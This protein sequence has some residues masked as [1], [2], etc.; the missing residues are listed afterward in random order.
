MKRF[1][2]WL[3]RRFGTPSPD[4]LAALHEAD[5]RARRARQIRIE[6][7]EGMGDIRRIARENGF[8]QA[9]RATLIGRSV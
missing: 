5:E 8:E 1:Q 7:D 4:A 2:V 9:V 3:T 6:A